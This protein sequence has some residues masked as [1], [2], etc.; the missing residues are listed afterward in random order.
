MILYNIFLL[1][2]FPIIIFSQENSHVATEV[3]IKS[4]MRRH[5]SQSKLPLSD[6]SSNQDKEEKGPHHYRHFRCSKC[7]ENKEKNSKEHEI[8]HSIELQEIFEKK[9]KDGLNIATINAVQASDEVYDSATGLKFDPF[10][11][12]TLTVSAVIDTDV[13]KNI[14]VPILSNS[15]TT[16]INTRRFRH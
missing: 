7:V 16:K 10:A 15:T 2:L 12:K 9:I 4:I 8:E 11:N 13:D 6:D 14:S 5:H 3:K 1:I